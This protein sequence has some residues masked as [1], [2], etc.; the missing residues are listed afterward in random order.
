MQTDKAQRIQQLTDAALDQLG[1]SLAAGKSDTLQ[2]Y[3]AAMAKFHRYSFG[4]QLLIA[5]Q[6]PDATHVAGYQTWKKLGRY[7]KAGE[8][9][10]LIIAPVKRRVAKAELVMSNGGNEGEAD[11]SDDL[12]RVVSF[13]GAYVFDISQTDGQPLPEFAKVSGEPADYTARLKVLA[14]AK[15]IALEYATSL[16]GAQ[17]VSCG[18]RI[19]I[20]LGLEPATEFSVLAHELAHELLHRGERRHQVSKKVR[21]TDAEAVAF[22][23]CQS[24]GLETGTAASDYIQLYNG[25]RDTLAESLTHIRDTASE[26]ILAIQP[27]E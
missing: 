11:G 10:I 12:V 22:V 27:P 18:N 19:Q 21:E 24:I 3:L 16:G 14:A 15:G 26:I 13:T 7:V 2:R 25:D 8:K 5:F 1:A 4:N 23:V 6:R 17:G 9:G 20:L